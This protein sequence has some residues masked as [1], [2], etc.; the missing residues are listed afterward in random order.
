LSTKERIKPGPKP[1]KAKEIR[2]GL[3]ADELAR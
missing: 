3:M 1:G 2:E